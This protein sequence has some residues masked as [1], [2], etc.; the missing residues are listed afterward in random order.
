MNVPG[1]DNSVAEHHGHTSLMTADLVLSVF[2]DIL[3]T[4]AL[5]PPFSHTFPHCS[6][7]SGMAT[8]QISRICDLISDQICSDQ[9]TF[10]F[11]QIRSA[12]DQITFFSIRSDQNQIRSLFQS[13]QIRS[14][15]IRS[16]YFQSDRIGSDQICCNQIRTV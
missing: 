7:E 13:D 15:Q 6:V 11:N 1:K 16:L 12:S 3:R 10:F 5:T 14:D 2:A 4:C 9:I 8:Y